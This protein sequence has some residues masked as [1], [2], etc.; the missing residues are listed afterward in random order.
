M[1]RAHAA[2]RRSAESLEFDP[3][4]QGQIVKTGIAST[5]IPECGC[6][7]KTAESG[8]VTVERTFTC[9]LDHYEPAPAV[10][11]GMPWELRAREA[12]AQLEAI[13]A[14]LREVLRGI[15]EEQKGI[16]FCSWCALPTNSDA[17]SK[18][19][20]QEMCRDNPMR[21]ARDE[22]RE[23]LRICRH[24]LESIVAI[25]DESKG[26][27]G[28]HLNGKLMSWGEAGVGAMRVAIARASAAL[29]DRNVRS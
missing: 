12:E 17:E 23:A 22:A 24:E 13:D 20:H 1:R 28:Y 21:I 15:D 27:A 29:D 6:K 9:K 5:L 8:A 11:P 2:E 3:A 10:Q 26:I 25:A 7:V 19:A 4:L 14:H 18:R 16:A